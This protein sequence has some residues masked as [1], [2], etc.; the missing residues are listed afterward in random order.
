MVSKQTHEEIKINVDWSELDRMIAERTNPLVKVYTEDQI[1][2]LTQYWPRM[3]IDDRKRT[4]GQFFPGVGYSTIKGY[5]RRL[6]KQGYEFV[7]V[8]K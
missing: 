8:Q 4:I 6:K 2:Y 5:V 1:K 7:E 3:S